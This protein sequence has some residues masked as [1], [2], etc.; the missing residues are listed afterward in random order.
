MVNILE[1]FAARN[2]LATQCNAINESKPD[3]KQPPSPLSAVPALFLEQ[4]LQ[5]ETKEL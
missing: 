5:R 4:N 3:A 2:M 1:R